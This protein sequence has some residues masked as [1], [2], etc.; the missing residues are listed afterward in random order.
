LVYVS[1]ELNRDFAKKRRRFLRH[2]LQGVE[3]GPRVSAG[4]KL[5]RMRDDESRSGAPSN[6]L[7][8]HRIVIVG[9]AMC[10]LCILRINGPNDQL[11]L[12]RVHHNGVRR[13]KYRRLANFT[14]RLIEGSRLEKAAH[15]P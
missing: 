4:I 10:L 15:D 8:K 6:P 3:K 1:Q 2:H 13:A 7:E 9:Y 5:A 11:R 12:W 14:H